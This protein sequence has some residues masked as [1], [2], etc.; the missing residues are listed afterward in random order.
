MCKP[1]ASAFEK[2]INGNNNVGNG[3]ATPQV[4]APVAPAAPDP[5][6][7]ERQRQ[8][9]LARAEQERQAAERAAEAERQRQAELARQ[10]RISSGRTKIDE[11]FAP[12]DDGY[13]NNVSQSYNQFATDDLNRQYQGQ[14]GNLISTLARNSGLAGAARTRGIDALREQYDTAI[15]GIPERGQQIA[16][17][18]RS[19]V[20]SAKS[21][22]Y[23]ANDQDPGVDSIA[24]TASSRAGQLKQTNFSPIAQLMI[25]PSQFMGRAAAGAGAAAAGQGGGS[26]APALFSSTR[27]A[28][29][30]GYTVA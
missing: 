7:V 26:K 6:E 2:I 9:D 30:G 28:R 29:G 12:F 22:L 1:I 10:A 20:A 3:V 11:A 23:G 5:A 15:R 14:L 21:E 24:S 27:Q 13:Y 16:E 18:L 25:D 4:S 17:S 8:A 19:G